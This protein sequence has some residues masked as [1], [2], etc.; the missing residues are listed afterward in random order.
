MGVL[1]CLVFLGLRHHQR[2]GWARLGSPEPSFVQTV[3]A[4][5]APAASSAPD[6]PLAP[7]AP[8]AVAA[9]EAAV[10][11]PVPDYAPAMEA[12]LTNLATINLVTEE[13]K[14]LPQFIADQAPGVAKDMAIV[15][16]MEGADTDFAYADGCGFSMLAGLGNMK[17][18]S[19]EHASPDEVIA[20]LQKTGKDMGNYF[21]GTDADNPTNYTYG[22][23]TRSGRVGL[24][25]FLN[26][27]S[28]GPLRTVTQVG[29]GTPTADIPMATISPPAVKI[30]YKLAQPGSYPGAAASGAAGKEL[31]E[32]LNARLEAASNISETSQKDKTLAAVAMAAATAGVVD[33]T[34][35]S[36]EQMS[37]MTLRDATG[38]QAALV[39]AK[40]GLGK[41]AIEIAKGIS[42]I[43]ARDE[44]LVELAK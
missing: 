9:P 24:L 27:T 13:Q 42:E 4:S 35:S 32:V 21:K 5:Q 22:F 1:L 25:Q 31:R 16:W 34:R 19:W 41:D 14:M 15:S 10:N 11:P 28:V 17:R 12:E 6:A 29:S 40:R 36:I 3:Q 38:R 37:E 20:A 43:S 2:L 8:A 18:D 26:F 23:Q 44:T 39:L 30:R 33:I 7:E